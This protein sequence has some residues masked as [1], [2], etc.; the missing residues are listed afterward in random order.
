DQDALYGRARATGIL[1]RADHPALPARAAACCLAFS[2]LSVSPT[3]A[4]PRA[5]DSKHKIA[6]RR[7]CPGSPAAISWYVTPRLCCVV[8][9]SAG[10]SR[11][12]QTRNAASKQAIALATFSLRSPVGK[13]Q[14]ALPRL[15]CVLAHASGSDSRLNRRRRASFRRTSSVKRHVWLR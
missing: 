3:A 15:F 14:Y 10:N 8:A 13:E 5:A 12:V 2:A 9:Q 1:G 6:C 4:Y 7:L 11:S